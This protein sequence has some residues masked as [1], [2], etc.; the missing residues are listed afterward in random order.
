MISTCFFSKDRIRLDHA[1]L[2]CKGSEW[3]ASG[4]GKN[5]WEKVF[6][7]YYLTQ[8]KE[9]DSRADYIVPNNFGTTQRKGLC[10]KSTQ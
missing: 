3:I 9:D 1:I 10:L 5:C 2:T 6:Y 7:D 4:K 8:V